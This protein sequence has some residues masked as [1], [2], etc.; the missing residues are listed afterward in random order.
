MIRLTYAFVFS[1]RG[2]QDGLLAGR[3]DGMAGAPMEQPQQQQQQEWHRL[4]TL[5][6]RSILFIL[7]AP[8]PI[9]LC[10]PP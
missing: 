6:V 8:D 10:R 7:T 5:L 9:F 2:L 3:G 1:Q 4:S